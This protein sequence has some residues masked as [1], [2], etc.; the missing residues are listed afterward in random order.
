MLFCE[1][2]EGRMGAEGKRVLNVTCSVQPGG[3]LGI[4]SMALCAC[5]H[6]TDGLALNVCL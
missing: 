5:M 1:R 2:V 6:L 4:V 3:E